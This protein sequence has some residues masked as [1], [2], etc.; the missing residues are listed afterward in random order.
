MA[1]MAN[2]PVETEVGCG[3]LGAVFHGRNFWPR[4]HSSP[5]LPKNC[6]KHIMKP[7]LTDISKRLRGGLPET[8]SINRSNSAIPQVNPFEK[9]TSSENAILLGNLSKHNHP[10]STIKVIEY[11]RKGNEMTGNILRNPKKKVMD[12]LNPEELK[13]MGN[14]QYNRGRLEEALI[15]YDRAI[16]LDPSKASYRSNKSAALTGLGRFTEAVFECREAVKIDPCCHRAH[17][18]LAALY[19]RLGETEKAIS[20]YERSD[21]KDES[22]ILIRAQ[23]LK[24]ILIQC[25]EAHKLGD[26]NTLLKE[27][28]HAITMGADSVPQIYAMQAESLLKL[29][30]HEEACAIFIKG[31]NFDTDTCTRFFG[32]TVSAYVSIIRAQVEIVSGRLED[33]VKTALMA[34]RLDARNVEANAVLKRAEA[35]ASARSRG[36]HLYKQSKFLEACV[37]YTEGLEHDPHNSV[38]LCNRAACRIKLGQFEKS[39]EDCTV[40]LNLRPSYNK[41]RLRRAHC[42]SKLE[43]WEASIQDYELLIMETH[44]DEEVGRALFEAQVQLKRQQCEDHEREVRL[45]HPVATKSGTLSG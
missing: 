8:V 20:H 25:R 6:S 16:A 42:N 12:I 39:A 11:H 33:A 44:G 36:N 2:H 10:S 34:V 24:T 32:L 4:K 17:H 14:E 40:A 9:R 21:T 28:H 7:P 30:R 22:S 27:C 38:L 43:R 18:R 26:W 31:P 5:S 3:L 1:E 19:L 23:A 41:A 35:V 37:T 29:H 45:L 13:S 15:F